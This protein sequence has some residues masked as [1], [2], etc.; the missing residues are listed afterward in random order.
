MQEA[1]KYMKEYTKVHMPKHMGIIQVNVFGS[2]SLSKYKHINTELWWKTLLIIHLS[3]ELQQM[4]AVLANG[5]LDG[6][7]PF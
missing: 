6:E 1:L 2:V 5:L 7:L 3:S 4:S